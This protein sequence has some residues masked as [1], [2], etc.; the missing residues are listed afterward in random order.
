MPEAERALEGQAPEERVFRV[1]ADAALRGAR[2]HTDN[3]FKVELAKLCMIRA[4]T[5]VT[6]A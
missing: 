4:L 3:A 6:N 5:T 2:P 1:A